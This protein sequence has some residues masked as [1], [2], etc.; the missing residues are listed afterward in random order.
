[1]ADEWIELEKYHPEQGNLD[2][3]RHAWYVLTY[4]WTLDINY[5]LI[6][7]QCTDLKKLS[8]KEGSREEA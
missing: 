5:R 1:L 4:K 3:E 6:M 7:L 2:S 8:N